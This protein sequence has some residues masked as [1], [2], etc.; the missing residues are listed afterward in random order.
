[1]PFEEVAA[2]SIAACESRASTSV[3]LLFL[4]RKEIAAAQNFLMR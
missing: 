3:G 1:M 4:T 2:F